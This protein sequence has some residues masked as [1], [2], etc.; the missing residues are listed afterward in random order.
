MFAILIL[1]EVNL[2]YRDS[3]LSIDRRRGNKAIE[4]IRNAYSAGYFA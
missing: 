3:E 2:L 1:S 4:T